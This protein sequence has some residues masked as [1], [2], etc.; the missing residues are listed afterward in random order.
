[1]YGLQN[2]SSQ[3]ELELCNHYLYT[4]SIFPQQL[5]YLT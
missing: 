1:M 4:G 2:A 3:L 5:S